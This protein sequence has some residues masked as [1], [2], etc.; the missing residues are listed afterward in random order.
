MVELTRTPLLV[1][2]SLY[3]TSTS[4]VEDA[5]ETLADEDD[6]SP[7][8]LK[9]VGTGGV[10]MTHTKLSYLCKQE[11]EGSQLLLSNAAKHT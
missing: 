1:Q 6:V 2:L 4:F 5:Q 11:S 7:I 8:S 10:P 9:S 3:A